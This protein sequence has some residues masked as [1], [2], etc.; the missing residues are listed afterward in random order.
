MMKSLCIR[1]LGYVLFLPF[2]FFY[3]YIL[4]PVL[5]LVLVPGGL[6]LLFLVLGWR[7]GVKPFLHL[8]LKPGQKKESGS[9]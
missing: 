2:L 8:C 5:K 7:D 3:S 4:G 1:V 9:V 6:A